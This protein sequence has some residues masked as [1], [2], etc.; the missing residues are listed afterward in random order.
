MTVTAIVKSDNATSLSAEP[1]CET[2]VTTATAV[3]DRDALNS[4]FATIKKLAPHSKV[5][6]VLKANGYGHGMATIAKALPQADAFGVARIDEALSLRAEGVTK[7]IV[8][9]EGFFAPEEINILAVNNLQTIVHNQAQLDAICQ[10]KLDEPL[11][12]WLKIDTG[13]HRLGIAPEQFQH[14]YQTL[15][16][17]PNVQK[18]IVLMS[19][20]GCADDTDNQF[21]G[22]Q[23][24]QFDQLTAGLAEERSMANS[25]G[26]C[27]WPNSHYQWLR[28]GLMLYGVSPM[29]KQN[30]T[31]LAIKPVMTLKASVIA[32]RQVKAGETVGYGA[33]WQ[34]QQD[35]HIGVIAIGYGDGYPRHAG[36]GTPV[37]LNGRRVPLVGRVS[38]DM[39]TVDLG[40]NA[41]DQ[42]GDVATLWG[43]GL[44]VEEIAEHAGTIPYEL[45]CNITR[46]VQMLTN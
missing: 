45:L 31:E 13:M 1:E 46:R 4:N 7:P 6:A 3:I 21:S 5:L 37:L 8:L 30:A 14:F 10:A 17:Q 26:I 33:A 23:I 39:I 29:L 20:M 28:P 41:N 27:A 15:S 19:H 43:Q 18:P 2:K 35:T 34:A 44:P 16:A 40:P 24:A 36:N 32:I 25:A 38:M 9:L 12:V 11:K 22:E 42:L